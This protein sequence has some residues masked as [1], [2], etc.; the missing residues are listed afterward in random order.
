[1][2]I[3]ISH[4]NGKTWQPSIFAKQLKAEDLLTILVRRGNTHYRMNDGAPQ[5]V[6]DGNLE[7]Q[8]LQPDKCEQ[9]ERIAMTA[10]LNGKIICIYCAYHPEKK[11][12]TEI[13]KQK[14]PYQASKE[15]PLP[16][17]PQ[18]R[19]KEVREKTK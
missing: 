9:C 5:K 18:W 10:K 2:K 3:E 16:N 7:I 11:L 8:V 13:S 17:W 6:E 4:D 14:I 19:K 1:M 12:N 15:K